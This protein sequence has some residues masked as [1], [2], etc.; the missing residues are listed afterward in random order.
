MP[1]KDVHPY[2]VGIGIYLGYTP[3]YATFDAVP[4]EDEYSI[5]R[6]QQIDT[7]TSETS[8]TTTSSIQHINQS[9]QSNLFS[10]NI[11]HTFRIAEFQLPIELPAVVNPLCT[12]LHHQNYIDL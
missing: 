2:C 6:P 3:T 11:L 10:K 1:F 8:T 7:T 12:L 4:F 9:T 5:P